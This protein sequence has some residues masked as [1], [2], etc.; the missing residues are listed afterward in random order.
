M[1]VSGTHRGDARRAPDR[2]HVPGCDGCAYRAQSGSVAGPAAGLGRSADGGRS[3][4]AASRPVSS[5]E[6]RHRWWGSEAGPVPTEATAGCPRARPRRCQWRRAAQRRRKPG[7]PIAAAAGACSSPAA[8]CTG[9]VP[10]GKAHTRTLADGLDAAGRRWPVVAG[11]HRPLSLFFAGGEVGHSRPPA[12][13]Q[14]PG[15]RRGQGSGG[16]VRAP[17][18]RRRIQNIPPAAAP[19]SSTPPS[20]SCAPESSA[21]PEPVSSAPLG[22]RAVI[23]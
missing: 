12:P 20:A 11:S 5:R 15:G 16:Q 19:A 3:V 21:G 1:R 17:L 7:R 23:W 8:L 2:V 9:A 6:R 13:M 18:G 14:S 10:A 4:R 22:L